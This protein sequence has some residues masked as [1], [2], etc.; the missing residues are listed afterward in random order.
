MFMSIF[1]QF[2]S[3]SARECVQYVCM[4]VPLTDDFYIRS[5]NTWNESEMFISHIENI[6]RLRS[7][8]KSHT[9]EGNAYKNENVFIVNTSF[10]FCWFFFFFSFFN[11]FVTTFAFFDFSPSFPLNWCAMIKNDGWF[12]YASSHIF[13]L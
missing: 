3:E 5:K 2:F 13:A 10:D 7:E 9:I 8:T 4:W 1:L 12:Q 11:I 6:F